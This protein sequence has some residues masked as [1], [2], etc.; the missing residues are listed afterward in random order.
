MAMIN[1]PKYDEDVVNLGY[2]RRILGLSETDGLSII[3]TKNYGT[4]PT[5]PY[6]LND[7]YMYDG[8]VYI[9]KKNGSR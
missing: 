3:V 1:E 4:A 2:L 8:K 9:C 5:P 6:G 7:T